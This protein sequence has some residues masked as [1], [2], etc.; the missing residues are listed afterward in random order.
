ML[1]PYPNRRR[2]RLI[3]GKIPIIE[4]T[5]G[6]TN[7]TIVL[8]LDGKNFLRTTCPLG[9]DLKLNDYLTLYTEVLTKEYK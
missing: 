1:N 2:Y 6:P 9:A 4:I 5:P 8:D 3:L 7:Y